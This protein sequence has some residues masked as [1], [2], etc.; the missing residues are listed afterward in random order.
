[1]QCKSTGGIG[2][3]VTAEE[4]RIVTPTRRPPVK[5]P[6]L[7]EVLEQQ[8]TEMERTFTDRWEW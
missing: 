1:M 8:I 7:A 6:D 4:K 5:K 3:N 2:M